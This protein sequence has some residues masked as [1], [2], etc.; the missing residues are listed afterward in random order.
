MIEIYLTMPPTIN[1]YYCPRQGSYAKY[2]G[3]AGKIFR[4]KTFIIKSQ[5]KL[6]TIEGQKLKISIDFIFNNG[7]K[8]DIDNRIKPLLDALQFVQLI[9]DDKNIVQ[10]GHI[11]KYVDKSQKESFCRIILE[12]SDLETKE[13]KMPDYLVKLI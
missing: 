8:N 1:H 12:P 10:I 6:K 9:D 4:Q 11:N 7:Y 2:I 13:F 3:D 5:L